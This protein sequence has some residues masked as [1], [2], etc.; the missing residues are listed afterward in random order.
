MHVSPAR[1]L[2]AFGSPGNTFLGFYLPPS[3]P[4]TVKKRQGVVWGKD[5]KHFDGTTKVLLEALTH[6]PVVSTS[7]SPILQHPNLVW[8]GH[9]SPSQWVD[10]LAGSKYL[11]G[12]G[13][14]LLGPS[15]L[16]A[17]SQGCVYI[18]PLYPSPKKNQFSQHDWVA[19]HIGHPYV[20]S[21]HPNNLTE[22]RGCVLYALR[23]EVEGYVPVEFL[24][25]GNEGYGVRVGKIF[26]F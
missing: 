24:E 4:T 15:A 25:E 17:I 21:Y 2:T 23:A 16:Q 14:P 3:R 13:D 22:L 19:T 26:G 9:V 8:R 7:S 10:L 1:F 11:L 6:S 5:P 18:N 20:C 12:T